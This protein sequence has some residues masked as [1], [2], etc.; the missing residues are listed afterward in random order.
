[1]GTC[2]CQSL[3]SLKSARLARET[4]GVSDS[5]SG[6]FDL[7]PFS[8]LPSRSSSSPSSSLAPRQDL[9]VMY[10]S[11]WKRILPHCLIDGIDVRL[12]SGLIDLWLTPKDPFFCKPEHFKKFAKAINWLKKCEHILR[13]DHLFWLL[14]PV[15]SPISSIHSTTGTWTEKANQ[16]LSPSSLSHD[17][18]RTCSAQ[19]FFA[20]SFLGPRPVNVWLSYCV[21]KVE[22][23]DTFKRFKKKSPERFG[24]KLK[25]KVWHFW[26][27]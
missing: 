22:N 9:V 13:E 12:L 27:F 10:C 7:S 24:T 21:L 5:I 11:T 18:D 19:M 23:C 3:K 1:M 2:A 16:F 8:W 4:Q 14:T 25:F 20:I 17:W 6:R 15:P 26:W